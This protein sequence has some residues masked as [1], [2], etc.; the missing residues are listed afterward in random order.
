MT[1]LT[2]QLMDSLGFIMMPDDPKDSREY[3]Y[4]A[5]GP[6]SRYY[7]KPGTESTFYGIMS[8][9]KR[10]IYFNTDFHE[11]YIFVEIQEDGGTRKVFHGGVQNAEDLIT[12]LKL[13][14]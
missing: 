6:Y 1:W 8:K 9:G 2:P 7:N 12:I 14:Y 4:R 3:P 10:I 13:V 5:H 11:D